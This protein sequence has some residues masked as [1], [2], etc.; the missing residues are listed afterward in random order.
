MRLLV[1][2]A[3]G[4][5]KVVVDTAVAAGW[6][7]S[8]VI[9]T[10]DDAS[11]VLGYPVVTRGAEPQADAFIV[12]IGHNAVRARLFEERIAHGMQPGTVI[13]PSAIIADNVRIGAGT[14][15]APGVV[16]NVGSNVGADAILNTGCVVDHDCV[17]GDHA[18]VGP[19]AALCGETRI[20]DGVV[21][22]AGSHTI[23]VTHI[24]EWTVCGAGASVVS[25]L[26]A[27]VVA[28]GVPA[29]IVRGIE[30]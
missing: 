25:D 20:G 30:E 5:A 18:H 9:G 24:G 4:H 28:A 15:I 6:E 17:V 3:G 10:P 26:P 19:L 8:G 23:P 21:M 13:H 12:A 22:G 11:D 27:R 7:I 1:I 2:G 14:F 29:R 16:I